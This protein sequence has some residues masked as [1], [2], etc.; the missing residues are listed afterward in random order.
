MPGVYR[1]QLAGKNA[2]KSSF[3]GVGSTME[4]AGSGNA[5]LSGLVKDTKTAGA[6]ELDRKA[7]IVSK[8]KPSATHISQ[9]HY[10]QVPYPGAFMAEA[11]AKAS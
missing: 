7:V 10:G 2:P 6:K 4:N 9:Y 1:F 5:T 11:G 3:P 8:L